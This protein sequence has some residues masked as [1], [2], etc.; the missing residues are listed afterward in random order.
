VL[1][2]LDLDRPDLA[3]LTLVLVLLVHEEAA[4]VT[5]ADVVVAGV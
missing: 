3:R 1:D 5:M 4:L 2:R